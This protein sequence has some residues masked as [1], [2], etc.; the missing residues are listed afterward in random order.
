MTGS[1]LIVGLAIAAVVVA[2]RSL[3]RRTGVP[4]PVFLVVAGAVA[5]VL[6]DI[7]R[8]TLDPDVVFLGFLP[9]LVYHAGQATSPR[10]LRANAVP[11]GLGALG[12][13]V[14]TTAAVAGL[15]WSLVPSMS[16][17]AAFVLGAVV[18]PTDPVASTSVLARLGGPLKVTAIIEGESLVNDGVALTL[19]GL[20]LA[21]VT[22]PTG[23]QG[24]LLD[25]LRIAGGGVVFGLAVGFV[26]SRI[27]R[28]LRDP[29]S[30]VIV[31]L[32]VPYVAYLPAN[33]LGLSGVLATLVTGLVLGQ[34]GFASLS[35]SGRIQVAEFWNVLVFLLESIL[36]VLVGL[37]L[38]S[39]LDGIT[40]Y[41]NAEIALVSGC[42]VAAVIVVRF[43]WWLA[44]PTLRWRPEG[45]ILDTGAVPWQERVLLG[46]CGLRGAISLA[47]ALS[48][49]LTVSGSAF[50]DRSL[51][52]FATFCVIIVTL[53]G[54]G[55][56]LPWLLRRLSLTGD[57]SERRQ[58]AFAERR[59]TEAALRRLDQMVADE[60]VS[61]EIADVLRQTYEQRLER[62]REN[63]PDEGEAATQ[64]PTLLEVHRSLLATQRQALGRLYRD[65]E[66]S[67]AVMRQVRREIDLEAASFER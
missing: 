17:A 25:F 46:W 43:A 2:S 56:S 26:A 53:V 5:S 54:Q 11:I 1:M 55:T 12:L 62:T 40:G 41:S 39:I 16:L 23:F 32:L 6:P 42:T 13:V 4:Y 21:A 8:I 45:R 20:G 37:Q 44:V 19:F 35:P 52:I 29:A 58:H 24:D 3:A 63:Q 34:Q 31:S 33:S 15:A 61:D 7:P 27:R 66:I 50:P 22:A 10:E 28:P 14:V 47:A 65:H 49:P 59:C 36:F 67:F 64:G 18:A 51:M 60:A 30:R 48:I 38:P 9:P 57:V